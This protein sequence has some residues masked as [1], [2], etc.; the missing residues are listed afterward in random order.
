MST[1]LNYYNSNHED[2]FSSTVNADVTSLYEHFLKYVPDNGKIL[3]LGCG[4]G[5]DTKAFMEKGYKVDA[6]DGS[7][8]L[9]RLASEYTGVEVRCM[10]FKDLCSS[11]E[12]NAIWA[13]AS[14]LHVTYKELPDI[15][16]KI[17][18]ALKSNGIVYMSFKEGKQ[19]G[20]RDGR[21]YT[22]MTHETFMKL[23]GMTEGF[24][25]IEEWYSVDVRNDRT[26]RWYNVVLRKV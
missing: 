12:Y 14:L 3:D 24:K 22:D 7:E 15:F 21:Y 20:L 9:C 26:Q 11:D 10:D 16:M 8:E 4:S 5:R 2:F 23:M 25:M 13:C 6:T 19:E 1:S 17:N 18:T